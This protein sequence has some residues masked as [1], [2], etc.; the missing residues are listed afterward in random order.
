[1]TIWPRHV[2]ARAFILESLKD[3]P[4]PVEGLVECA[5][6]RYGYPKKLMVEEASKIGVL[7]KEINGKPYWER[8]PNLHAIWW[9]RRPG[10]YNPQSKKAGGAR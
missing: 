2:Y 3:K 8:P 4:R 6:S 9:G 5:N 1:M 10:T 7:T